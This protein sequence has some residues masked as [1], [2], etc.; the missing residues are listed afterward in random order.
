M[1]ELIMKEKSEFAEK[2]IQEYIDCSQTMLVHT[3]FFVTYVPTIFDLVNAL[4]GVPWNDAMH[5]ILEVVKDN[6]IF[7][8]YESEYFFIPILEVW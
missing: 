2:V 5:P 3:N 6:H 7:Y 4:P 1:N 8:R